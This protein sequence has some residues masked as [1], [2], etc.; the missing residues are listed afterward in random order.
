[1]NRPA[2]HHDNKI[3][4][5]V[6]TALSVTVVLGAGILALPGISYLHA[7]RHG[8]W[9]WLIMAVVMLPLLAIFSHFG[10][11]H[12]SA[13]GV[14]GYVRV[15]LGERWAAVTEMIVLGTLLVGLPSIALIGASYFSQFFGGLPDTLV[16]W[17]IISTSAVAAL[18]G[19]RLSG[20]VQTMIAV[21][22]LLGLLIITGGFLLTA[23]DLPGAL[24]PDRLNTPANTFP[25]MPMLHALP[26]IL[27]AYTGWELTAFLAEDMRHPQRDLPRSIW[28]SFI[29]VSALY[30]L[31][32]WAVAAHA[33]PTAGWYDTPIAQLA[34]GWLGNNGRRAV[35]LIAALLV[36]ANVMAAFL[37]TS[38]AMFSAGR[39]GL[40]PR[41]LATRNQHG[42]PVNA[43][44]LTWAACSLTLL[45][46]WLT[47]TP[48]HTL[49]QLAGQNF[50]VLYLLAA[51]GY[52][53]KAPDMA[54]TRQPG[55]GPTLATTGSDETHGNG[56][57]MKF[58]KTACSLS[59]SPR[60]PHVTWL[61]GALAILSVLGM[62]SLFQPLGMLYCGLL[63]AMGYVG[64]RWR[65][66]TPK[67]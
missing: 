46:A 10:R 23:P 5:I 27:F 9:P 54:S 35:G 31:M 59:S 50:F 7:G 14:V 48:T 15:S 3:G 11:H 39:D 33:Q 20:P 19:L 65:R 32:A 34:E 63:A 51:I 64:V 17:L 42:T 58:G 26:A 30:L 16:A 57:A 36:L 52:V 28:I 56:K 40:L 38:R 41:W 2:P 44:L 66:Q 37:S 55:R 62:M 12:P 60:K 29:L 67:T 53:A 45:I 4:L 25:W 24:S 1:M 61:I 13:G 47:R 49:L 18:I 22:I 6:A 8:H 21:L 43:I